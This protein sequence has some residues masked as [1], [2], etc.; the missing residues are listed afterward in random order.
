MG[1]LRAAFPAS[2]TSGKLTPRLGFP[3]GT[4]QAWVNGKEPQVK[5][6]SMAVLL[7]FPHTRFSE[8]LL[9]ASIGGKDK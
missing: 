9:S 4:A 7:P 2:F 3:N 8:V 6:T 5:Q 1:P